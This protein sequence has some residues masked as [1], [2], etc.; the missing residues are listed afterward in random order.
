MKDDPLSRLLSA[1]AK[2]EQPAEEP[3]P[4]GFE[5]RVLAQWR[6]RPEDST[7]RIFRGALA[8]GCAAAVISL[9]LSYQ[10]LNS[11]PSTELAIA[12]NAIE[13]N[14]TP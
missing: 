8:F 9:A 14:F 4:F 13:A 2:A 12:N 7:L 11:S 3:I 6:K 1:A 10:T 5:T